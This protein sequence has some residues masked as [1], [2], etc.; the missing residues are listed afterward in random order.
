MKVVFVKE[1]LGQA[2]KGE[3]K[4]V[5]SGYARNYLLPKGIAVFVND[6]AGR[7]AIAEVEA[8]KARTELEIEELREKISE[9]GEPVLSFKRKL[10]QKGTLFNAVK[11][12]EIAKEF[13]RL[14]K[15]EPIKIDL[16][17]TIK[18]LSEHRIE[19]FLPHEMSVFAKIII[20]AE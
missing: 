2:K 11:E 18:E 14:T 10:T 6:S 8:V 13:A 19:I 3:I 9:I 4:E 7:Q 16:S 12:Q 20:L 15:I 17:E 5:K 1:V